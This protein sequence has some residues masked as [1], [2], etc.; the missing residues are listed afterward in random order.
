MLNLFS[1]EIF[2]RFYRLFIPTGN[3]VTVGTAVDVP[4]SAAGTHKPCLR[5]CRH[6]RHACMR[7]PTVY[8]S[9]PLDCSFA[10]RVHPETWIGQSDGFDEYNCIY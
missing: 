1:L 9:D 4:R 6:G 8:S 5:S 2:V 3:A 10:F 7:T